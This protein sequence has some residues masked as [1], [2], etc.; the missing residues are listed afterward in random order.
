MT[1]Y[2]KEAKI[3]LNGR[4]MSAIEGQNLSEAITSNG[5]ELPAACSRMSKNPKIR[6]RLCLVEIEGANELQTACT[7]IVSNGMVVRTNTQEIERLRKENLQLLF[8]NYH[9]EESCAECIWDG[10]CKF[11]HLAQRYGIRT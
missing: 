7:E 1:N 11:F 9:S 5:I 6:C 4:D 3:S 10:N 2:R 8:T